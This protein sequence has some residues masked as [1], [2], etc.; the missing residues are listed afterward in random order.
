MRVLI[1]GACGF[2]GRA[3]TT[4][5]ENN[6]HELRL[7]DRVDPK[8]ATVFVPGSH[9]RTKEPFVTQ[10][11]YIRAEVT[12]EQ[13]MRTAAE[14]M[15]AIIHLGA[16]TTGLPEAGAET[17]RVNTVGTFIMLDAARLTG[18]PRFIC[19]SSIN[20]FGTFYWRLSGKPIVY[21]KMPLDESFPPVPEDPYSLSK[22]VNEETCAAFHRAYG[23]TTAAMRFAGVLS[24]EGYRKAKAEM[25]PTTSW[26]DDLYCWVH[27]QDIVEG[28]RAALEAPNLPGFG[29][30]TLGAGDTSRPEPT[31]EL[32]T[33]FRPDLARTLEKPLEGREPL[34][35]IKKAQH[36]F[37][38]APSYRL[39][40]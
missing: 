13:A 9:E 20:A 7:V 4:V 39:G 29:V 2:L 5:L 28:L 10:W 27:I 25:Q 32:L 11:P 15:D 34:L 33:R 1:T 21:T 8:E 6:A 38:Y 19:A 3:L 26:A 12:D 37:G 14:G 18:V 35:S 23:I 31:M 36:A 40:A 17:F 22:L 30:Y 16:M 24:D